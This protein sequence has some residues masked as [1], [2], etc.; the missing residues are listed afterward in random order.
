MFSKYYL[1][2][3]F[4]LLSFNLVNLVNS[5]NN[6][7]K[8]ETCTKKNSCLNLRNKCKCYCSAEC[9]FRNKTLEDRPV[10]DPNDPEKKYCYCK[11]WDK[12]AFKYNCPIKK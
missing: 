12:D 4:S 11:Q 6:N 7:P 3:L 9:K 10:Y 5:A 2:T 8:S 1:I